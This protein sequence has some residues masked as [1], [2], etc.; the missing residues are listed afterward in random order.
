[1]KMLLITAFFL[2]P[3]LA[4]AQEDQDSEGTLHAL[5]E[6]SIGGGVAAL[7]YN[8]KVHSTSDIYGL[9]PH[10]VSPHLFRNS[11]KIEE[12]V[13]HSK[14]GAVVTHF[15]AI[16]EFK[17]KH[18]SKEISSLKEKLKHS[19]DASEIERR[20]RD[21]A[22]KEN[23]ISKIKEVLKRKPADL[24]EYNKILNRKDLTVD[25]RNGLLKSILKSEM[26][27][28]RELSNIAIFENGKKYTQYKRVGML[29]T[30]V[31]AAGLIGMITGPNPLEFGKKSLD[32]LNNSGREIASEKDTSNY[33]TKKSENHQDAKGRGL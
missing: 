6:R 11:E 2:F 14:P 8:A 21:I 25:Q 7:G 10:R 16:E 26:E 13:K 4:L 3:V 19:S 33:P 23:Q 5:A 1:M 30:A 12:I 28:G 32:R 22:F 24:S 29:G 20:K 17:I 27:K 31:T 15:K 18:L 9:L